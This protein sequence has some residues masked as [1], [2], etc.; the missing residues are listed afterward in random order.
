MV[1]SGR[2]DEQVRLR[3]RVAHLATFF[4]EQPPKD[5]TDARDRD[6]SFIS[7]VS[8]ISKGVHYLSSRES[9]HVSHEPPS[10]ADSL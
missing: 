6:T 10:T 4:D 5:A 8:F 7:F 9:H 1:L 3:E 2:R